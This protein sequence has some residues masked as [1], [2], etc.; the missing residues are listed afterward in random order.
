MAHEFAM[1]RAPV[2][3]LP[4]RRHREVAHDL[5]KVAILEMIAPQL[6]EDRTSV[7]AQDARHLVRRNLCR[8]P[9]LDLPPFL[10]AQLRVSP[11]HFS[12]PST[13]QA[14][15]I[16]RKSQLEVARTQRVF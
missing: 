1:P 13:R 16:E 10:D 3:G 8:S 9:T 11:T 15:V 7:P 12:T 2:R 5:R 14:I 4:L 6:P